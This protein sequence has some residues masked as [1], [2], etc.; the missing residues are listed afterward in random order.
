MLI[1][2]DWRKSS[3]LVFI[4]CLLL[5]A[6]LLPYS[7]SPIQIAATDF[8]SEMNSPPS[9]PV[10]MDNVTES[11]CP[12][13]SVN[14][15][16]PSIPVFE[17]IGGNLTAT[18]YIEK[19]A[20][21]Y[22]TT[23]RWDDD[24]DEWFDTNNDT[25]FGTPPAEGNI[26]HIACSIDN[27]TGYE[28]R[29]GL[30]PD[31][32]FEE[33]PFD[34]IP[35]GG[36]P[37][38]TGFGGTDDPVTGFGWNPPIP[39]TIL[40]GELWMFVASNIVALPHTSRGET[41]AWVDTSLETWKTPLQI[42]LH[43]NVVISGLVF[44]FTH[45]D[46]TV[47]R[48]YFNGHIA[49]SK[50]YGYHEY[51]PEEEG[52]GGVYDEYVDVTD[53][54]IW[55]ETYQPIELYLFSETSSFGETSTVATFWTDVRLHVTE[56]ELVSPTG[57]Y[58]EDLDTHQR[59]YFDSQGFAEFYTTATAWE[60]GP[61]PHHYFDANWTISATLNELKN[62]TTSFSVTVDAPYVV[63]EVRSPSSIT[64]SS[65]DW[66]YSRY[67]SAIPSAWSYN[68]SEPGIGAHWKE[69][70]HIL[71]SIT[72]GWHQFLAP[73]TAIE[74]IVIAMQNNTEIL[75]TPCLHFMQG[76]Q[77]AVNAS[78]VTGTYY[79]DI[80]TPFTYSE[81]GNG[82]ISTEEM[83]TYNNTGQLLSIPLN[84]PLGT[85]T[86]VIRCR[87]L[88]PLNQ[89][90]Y[91]STPFY[92]NEYHITT[93]E[94]E[95]T[96]EGNVIVTG[97]LGSADSGDY[98]VY[99]ARAILQT[100]AINGR[101]DRT[102]GD[103]LLQEWYQTDCLLTVTG[104]S[105]DIRFSVNNTGV[106]KDNVTVLVRFMSVLDRSYVLFEKSS[107]V[108]TWAMNE[109]QE[110]EWPNLWIGPVGANT[111]MRR[112]FYFME[113]KI[114]ENSIGLQGGAIGSF[115]AVTDSPSM[116]GRV[117]NIYSVP[118]DYPD[119][120][121]EFIRI[122]GE[123]AF[124]ISNYFL[125]TVMDTH[126]ITADSVP[127]CSETLRLR[128]N[129]HQPYYANHSYSGCTSVHPNGSMTAEAWLYSESPFLTDYTFSG[130]EFL[131][132]YYVNWS[133]AYEYWGS[134]PIVNWAF[135]GD[136]HGLSRLMV[137]DAE[138]HL[139][140][141]YPLLIVY[142]GDEFTHACNLTGTVEYAATTISTPAPGP[143]NSVNFGARGT[144][145]ARLQ[146]WT[147]A[148]D[149]IWSNPALRPIPGKE[150]VFTIFN[151]VSWQ[152]LGVGITASD[153]WAQ[154]T[155][156]ANFVPS[157]HQIRV[158]FSGSGF[159]MGSMAEYSVT[160]A[161]GLLFIGILTPIIIVPIVIAVFV[162]RKIRK[163]RLAGGE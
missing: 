54:F 18:P 161:P 14:S 75:R 60:F 158:I 108:T 135:P 80:Y 64:S 120:S 62:M 136:F 74:D 102:L 113:L 125:V 112:G 151:G 45:T 27:V 138:G 93:L 25:I 19:T 36:G 73:N 21:A 15:P 16:S 44:P 71:S 109:V 24:P 89:V 123:L 49:W 38:S 7:V 34:D 129:L 78:G 77:Y 94:S 128:T 126:H 46:D 144:C 58:L 76:E 28:T 150:L 95:V 69:P 140:A 48:V 20:S 134:A 143:G 70:F 105:I 65:P 53:W 13:E 1:L 115:L 39:T 142:D 26:G 91:S 106:Q 4:L 162:I 152:I 117:P 29:S 111:M 118:V 119:F 139:P 2:G 35:P 160:I 3:W 148:M 159:L 47:V 30:V 154:I 68:Q 99:C 110:F 41:R 83:W 153:G 12:P 104:E 50:S 157:A 57:V 98:T 40:P 132:D 127:V 88:D 146:G 145:M 72:C 17:G 114:N 6:P 22:V 55:G 84:A 82:W 121:R 86:A 103:M 97:Q 63:W 131:L 59:Y 5:G 122:Y 149:T 147:C 61:H 137:D 56:Y 31:G 156:T 10:F 100:P 101:Y 92:V 116:H 130:H 51:D 96:P 66:V 81:S 42:L 8:S 90:G 23:G 124:P 67:E 43:F 155:Y 85:Y 133:T 11:K 32:D 9:Q 37:W 33:W 79:L 87:G 163:G 141:S 52:F 107:V